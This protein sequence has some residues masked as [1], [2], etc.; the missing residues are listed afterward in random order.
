MPY[1]IGSK[2]T[3]YDGCTFRSRNEA[4]FA[5][6]LNALKIPWEYEGQTYTFELSPTSLLRE[7]SHRKGLLRYT[8]DFYLP[9]LDQT[10]ELKAKEP[11]TL[12]CVK[13]YLLARQLQRNIHV[14]WNLRKLYVLTVTPKGTFHIGHRVRMCEVCQ[15]VCFWVEPCTHDCLTSQA[16]VFREA[17]RRAGAW[18][19]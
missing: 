1:T 6:F 19:I 18:T 8:P 4:K 7:E 10:I 5:V 16:K 15:H 9:S 11:T 14:V 17:I 13:V 3:I 2:E 12:E